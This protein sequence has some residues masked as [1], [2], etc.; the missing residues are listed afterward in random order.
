MELTVEQALQ[1][2]IAAHKEGK[3][4]E[5]ERLYRAI[6]Q[7]QP[8]HPDANHNLGV[9][10]V[11]VNKADAALPLFK[12]ALEANPKIEQFWLSYIDA[13]IKTEKVDD[14]RR[15]LDEAQKAGVTLAKLEIF[16][17]QLKFELSSSIHIPQQEISNPLHSHQGELS[18]AIE[19]REIGR[20][21]EAQD[22]LNNVLEHDSKNTEALS[23]L[24]QVLLLDKKEAEAEKALTA[25]A[26]INSELPSVYRNQARLLLKQ[27]KTLEALEKAQLGCRQS[28]EEPESLLVL[29]ACLGANQRDLEALPIIEK[30]LKTKSNYAEAYANRALIKTRAKD[31][32]G[33]IE[34][35][36]MTVSLKP[37]LTQMWQ[38]LS[39]LHYQANNLSDAIETLRSA[40]KN[41]PENPDFMVQLGE[42]LR[43]DNKLS[44]AIIILEQATELVPKDAKAWTNLGVAF[45]QEKRIVDAKIAYEKAL[46]LNPKSA[47]ILSNLGAMAKDAKEWES[48]LQYF[49]KALEIEPNLSEAHSN[50]GITLKELGRLGES[51]ASLRQA[52]AL[53]PDFSEAH[54]N[55]G[56][57]LNKLGRLDEAEASYTQAI[58]L[59][60][61]FAE[62]HSNLGNTLKELGRLDEAEASCRQAIVVK[63][64]FAEAYLNLCEFLEKMNRTDEILPVIKSASGKILKNTADF[65]YFEAL[66]E[67][68]KENYE[69]AEEIVKKINID[70]LLEKNQLAAMKLQ[71]DLYH[72]K[73]DYSA[74][75]EA[76][77][78]KNKY[79]KDSLEYKGQEPEK[80]YIQQREKVV[81]IEQLQEQ[82]A[83]KS[84]IKPSWIQPTFLIGFPRSGTTLLDTIL[85]THSNIDVLEELP[86]L[87]KMNARLG[88]ITTFSKIEAMDNIAAEIASGYYFEELKKYIEI[89]NKQ[90]IV[91]KLPLNILQLPLINQIFPNAKYIIALRH[92]LDCALSCWMQDFELNPAMAN[93]IELDRIVDF[94]DVA[95]SILKLSEERYSLDTH[96][97]RYEDLVLD[98]E[99]NVS[100]LLTF[101]DLKWE[102]KLRSY[103]NTALARGKINTPSYSQVI[104]PLYKTASYRWKNYEEYLEPYK[105][106]LAPWIKEYGYSS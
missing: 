53:K 91:D 30:L 98:F 100:S 43:Q 5:A 89:G 33:A 40:H 54:N 8:A 96:R 75:F 14:V 77:K 49:E 18:V 72:H 61:D 106:R 62:A 78:S 45:Q 47:V 94:Y 63:P 71:G 58:A 82:S 37:H 3:F 42:F 103:Q 15:V 60:P 11:S 27:S 50:L 67:F 34:D 87:T 81:Q 68:R 95:N 39:S 22:W 10:A 19:L 85:R 26:S 93:M 23:L 84:V 31:T 101:L 24:S 46:A 44:E 52:I 55:L 29:A 38:L 13:L 99:G 56:A 21:K 6:L 4:Q 83:Y 92:P 79:V 32:I 59:N 35:A 20:Y 73:K 80:Y 2:G 16:E 90:I 12:V 25:A 41:E 105:S 64:D 28:P 48:A 57:V 65:L 69:T 1:Q 88:D 7:S 9:I 70:E 97:I 74:A 66:I 36:E 86:M 17:E 76:Y 51:E 104:K 102:E